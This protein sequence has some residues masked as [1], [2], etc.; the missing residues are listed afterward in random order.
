MIN[1]NLRMSCLC[2]YFGAEIMVTNILCA[3]GVKY[4]D[5]NSRNM[6]LVNLLSRAK[7]QRFPIFLRFLDFQTT[8]HNLQSSGLQ[9]FKELFLRPKTLR[10]FWILSGCVVT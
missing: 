10:G 9:S 6:I 3:S 1:T 4:G 8:Q 7:S 5:C 2:L